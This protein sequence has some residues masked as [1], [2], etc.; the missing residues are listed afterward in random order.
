M[1]RFFTLVILVLAGNLYS[2]VRFKNI[3]VEDGLSQSTVHDILFDSEGLVWF[4]TM[5]GLN[6]YDG[7]DFEVLKPI[8]KDSSSI[9]SERCVK[10]L[11]APSG[12]LIIGTRLGISVYDKGTNLF[13]NIDIPFIDSGIR[14]LSI[15][16]M[17]MMGD[18]IVLMNTD[19]GLLKISQWRGS[20][21]DIRL[22]IPNE[23]FIINDIKK[24]GDHL[25]LASENGLFFIN[26]NFEMTDT[27]SANKPYSTLFV[28]SQN[29]LLSTSENKLEFF[30]KEG[31][32]EREL[33]FDQQI[34]NIRIQE[35]EEDN[36]GCLWL[37]GGTVWRICDSTIDFIQH[38]DTPG[39]LAG[40][41]AVS[42]KCTPDGMMFIGTDG[43]GLSIYDKRFNIF[44]RYFKYLPGGKLL[45]SEN[46]KSFF[47]DNDVEYLIGTTNGL[48][49][50]N[51]SSQEIFH[52]LHSE[53]ELRVGEES[54]VNTIITWKDSKYFVGTGTGLYVFDSKSLKVEKFDLFN[55]DRQVRHL[56]L[57]D[58]K[59]NLYIGTRE[60][61]LIIL[62]L[63]TDESYSFNSTNKFL[64]I[65]GNFISTTLLEDS[66]LWIGTSNGLD[67]IN[68]KDTTITNF[69]FGIHERPLGGKLVKTI[70]RHSKGDLF[71]GTWGG[72][73]DRI[74]SNGTI[75]SYKVE[76]GLANNV[77]YGL[78]EDTLNRIWISTNNGLSLFYPEEDKFYTFNEVDGV[79]TEFN[80]GAY[81]YRESG[82]MLFGG[83]NGFVVFE[84]ENMFPNVNPPKSY[85]K[86]YSFI[87]NPDMAGKSFRI[88]SDTLNITYANNSLKFD[89]STIDFLSPGKRT[90]HF[91]VEGPG[92]D[93]DEFSSSG[94]IFLRNLEPGFYTLSV[95]A[96]NRHG[97]M[98]NT[99]KIIFINVLTPFYLTWWFKLFVIL[100]FFGGITLVVVFRD[101]VQA[102]RRKRLQQIISQRTQELQLKTNEITAQ[103][104]ELVSQSETLNSQNNLLEKKTRELES[105]KTNLENEVKKRTNDLVNIN[106]QLVEQNTKLEQFSFI[107]AHN[108]KAPIARFLGLI[109]LSKMKDQSEE[110]KQNYLQLMKESAHELDHIVIDLSETLAI[111]NNPTRQFENLNPKIILDQVIESLKEFNEQ[112]HVKIEAIDQF[113]STLMG[114]KSYYQSIFYNLIHNAIKYSNEKVDSWIKV[115]L[116]NDNNSL[117]IN[118]E[119]NGIGIDMKYAQNKIFNLYQRFNT[120]YSGKGFG[121]YLVKT[122]LDILSGNINVKSEPNKGTTFTIRIPLENGN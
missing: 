26:S 54:Y 23:D 85:I 75:V 24:F 114:I 68:F 16:A 57:D 83:V 11:E 106:K 103:N 66:I 31:I 91:T 108:L 100:L 17:C 28:N 13:K 37:A 115:E 10:I 87:N 30:N 98:D 93:I 120:Q 4:A 5:D 46:I 7:H 32:L 77:V 25:A 113:K 70:L 102:Q 3:S 1:S 6:R 67:K 15:S 45:S 73:V 111:K 44:R 12:E 42:L 55:N 74:S 50:Y 116:L 51:D 38:T 29:L 71:V 95:F 64:P 9:A 92:L 101:N 40:N 48:N 69:G 49:Y 90:F 105:I 61:G 47:T 119:D 35:I 88:I 21:P 97:F 118:I 8:A 80:T 33:I 43:F 18:S 36:V 62:N 63:N 14:D 22:I 58:Q 82:P 72:G 107:I 39:A 81:F 78:L 60:N 27:L 53:E 65:S 94:E 104:E 96:Q 19:V 76:N 112:K 2:Q 79:N 41:F 121:L 109:Q 84:P 34:P 110:S 20:E 86:S 56:Y 59:Q 52:F 122:Q 89:A 117:L 99:G